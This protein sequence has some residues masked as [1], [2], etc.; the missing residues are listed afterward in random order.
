MQIRNN[1]IVVKDSDTALKKYIYDNFDLVS[2]EL[3]SKLPSKDR[4][5]AMKSKPYN[6]CKSLY[7]Q[8]GYYGD[9]VIPRGILGLI[10]KDILANTK[11]ENQE[12]E[13]LSENNEVDIE[14]LAKNIVPGIT[15]RED[16]IMAIKKMLLV[17]RC[18]V[19]LSTGSG[20]S[21]IIVGFLKAL[22]KTLGR[23]PNVLILEPTLI[24]VDQMIKLLRDAGIEVNNYKEVV[25]DFTGIVVGHPRSVKSS[26]GK[27]PKILNNLEVMITDE[28]HHSQAITYQELMQYANNLHYSVGVSASIFDNPAQ[29]NDITKLTYEEASVIGFSGPLVMY[30]PASY[31]IRK[32]ILSRPILFRM[33]N[34]ANEWVFDPTNWS[35][36][37]K[38]QLESPKRT[39]LIAGVAAFFASKGYKILIMCGT[40]TYAFKLMAILNCIGMNDITR[41]SFGSGAFYRFDSDKLKEV[42]ISPKKESTMRDFESGKIKILLGT[43]HIYEGV[44]VPNLD[45]V[46]LAGVGKSER[47]VVQSVG[48]S[49]RRTKTGKYAYIIDFTDHLSPV[50]KS[51]ARKRMITYRDVIGVED[52]DIYDKLSLMQMKKIFQELEFGSNL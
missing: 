28:V 2:T 51:Q 41:A 44:D 10:P 38:R 11:V 46:I 6:V 48:R 34:E 13:L 31:Y 23:V 27:N 49:L 5:I 21:L 43:S 9:I 22:I 20:K 1:L 36:V 39:E 19:Q 16:Q 40:K 12:T 4:E 52:C 17:K 24:L 42:K 15:L 33:W 30:L 47:R 50:L 35:A 18:V 7:I 25:D 8:V 45:A 3:V 37:R 26:I 14:E 29:A 32:G